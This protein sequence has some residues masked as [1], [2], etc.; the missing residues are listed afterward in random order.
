MLDFP[1]SFNEEIAKS[2]F[3]P[4]SDNMQSKNGGGK[5]VSTLIVNKHGNFP[6]Q[7]RAKEVQEDKYHGTMDISREN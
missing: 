6:N 1:F 7:L 2:S 5:A 3:S 4:R